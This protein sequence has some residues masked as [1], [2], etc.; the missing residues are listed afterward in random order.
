MGKHETG[1]ALVRRDLYPTPFWCIRTLAEHVELRDR[2]IWECAA[3]DGRMVRALETEG[4]RAFATDVEPYARLDAMLDF[5]TQGPPAG[6]AHF[7]GVL[8][9]PAWGAG[10]RLAVAFIEAGLT[11]LANHG[12]FLALLLPADF[13]SAVTRLRL[14][15]HPYVTA[16]IALTARPVWFE[17]S[18]AVKAAPK[19]NCA[20]FVWSRPVLRSPSPPLVQHAM[21][22]PGRKNR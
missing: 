3:G 10:S 11:R 17:R 16:R 9:N 5:L 1:C 6:L 4:A 7:D 2:D 12:G 21:A 13:D 19:A 20:R 15:Q 18:D 14:F 22:R 8:T